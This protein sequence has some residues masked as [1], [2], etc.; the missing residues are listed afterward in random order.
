MISGQFT[1]DSKQIAVA[2]SDGIIY[3]LE[4]YEYKPLLSLELR[5]NKITPYPA[6][7]RDLILCIGHFNEMIIIRGEKVLGSYKTKDWIHSMCVGDVNN[8]GNKEVVLG[9]KNQTIQ[10]IKI[11]DIWKDGEDRL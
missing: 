11:R 3:I 6:G 1:K 4:D 2:C 5:I 8:D 7:R 10:I 9:M